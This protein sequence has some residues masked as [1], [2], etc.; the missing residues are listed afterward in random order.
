M[1][2]DPEMILKEFQEPHV[3]HTKVVDVLIRSVTLH[4]RMVA[5]YRPE[6]VWY[7]VCYQLTRSFI[8]HVGR[9]M[10]F[11][12]YHHV[13]EDPTEENWSY[14]LAYLAGPHVITT[15]EQF[16]R[17]LERYLEGR[18]PL[19]PAGEVEMVEFAGSEAPEAGSA[20]PTLPPEEP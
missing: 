7:L 4:D 11:W 2:F 13:C 8:A 9:E 20:R 15:R 18:T 6:K 12:S 10:S 5:Y 1:I 16:K 19:L 17:D 14:A 3:T